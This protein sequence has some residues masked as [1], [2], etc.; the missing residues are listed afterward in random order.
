MRLYYNATLF[1]LI[2]WLVFGCGA[3]LQNETVYRVEGDATIH[4][5]VGVDV[6]ACEGLEGEDKAEC[7]QAMIELAKVIQ[8][9]Q[10]AQE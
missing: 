1:A 2:L 7:I 3:K 8:Q 10:G 6:T 4:V 9:T 5:V